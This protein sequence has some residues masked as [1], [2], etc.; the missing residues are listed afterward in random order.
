[1][2]HSFSFEIIPHSLDISKGRTFA[3]G[4]LFGLQ[5]WKE[6]KRRFGQINF[7]N[8]FQAETDE[9]LTE[10]ETEITINSILDPESRSNWNIPVAIV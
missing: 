1:M 3:L 8:S 10:R 5:D 9:L 6:K 2:S 4:G 7:N